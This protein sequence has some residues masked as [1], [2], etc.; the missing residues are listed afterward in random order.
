MCHK[1]VLKFSVCEYVQQCVITACIVSKYALK[2]CKTRLLNFYC[3]EKV[4]FGYSTNKSTAVTC[5]NNLSTVLQV[6]SSITQ[7]IKYII[8]MEMFLPVEERYQD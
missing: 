3:D 1:V 6:L 2:L 4:H 8:L 5:L 7:V